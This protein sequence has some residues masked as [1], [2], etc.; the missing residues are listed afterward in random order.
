MSVLL[1]EGINFLIH[2]IKYYLIVY[3][4]GGKDL[5]SKQLFNC[6]RIL[7]PFLCII[8]HYHRLVVA[9]QVML[10]NQISKVL[11]N[12]GNCFTESYD[13]LNAGD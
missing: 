13:V 9:K 4:F 10:V 11:S 2:L 1:N 7:L 12:N 8:L 6:G 5:G 3:V